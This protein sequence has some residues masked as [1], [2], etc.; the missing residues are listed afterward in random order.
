MSKFY[1]LCN[2]KRNLILL[3]QRLGNKPKRANMRSPD[4]RQLGNMFN[5]CF[6][7]YWLGGGEEGICLKWPDKMATIVNSQWQGNIRL[8]RFHLFTLWHFLPST[9]CAL[10]VCQWPH[11]LDRASHEYLTL[12]PRLVAHRKWII[13][14]GLCGGT[15]KNSHSSDELPESLCCI[16]QAKQ[17]AINHLKP[18]SVVASHA[19]PHLKKKK[20]PEIRLLFKLPVL[21]V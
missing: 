16:K 5:V 1:S 21:G 4:F 18:S 10:T 19:S 3:I 13:F 8:H 14:S 7:A 17:M 20:F 11:Q 12:E 6:W 9:E 15:V 2:W